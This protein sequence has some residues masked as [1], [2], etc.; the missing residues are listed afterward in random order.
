MGAG[1][2]YITLFPTW[3]NEQKESPLGPDES[4]R[5]GYFR[6]WPPPLR[7]LAW[8]IEIIWDVKPR[9]FV[10]VDEDKDAGDY[11]VYFGRIEALG[12]DG[13]GPEMTEQSGEITVSIVLHIQCGRAAYQPLRCCSLDSPAPACFCQF[14][15]SSYLYRCLSTV[16]R[17]PRKKKSLCTRV[18]LQGTL[19]TEIIKRTERSSPSPENHCRSWKAVSHYFR[20]LPPYRRVPMPNCCSIFLRS[21]IL[22]DKYCKGLSR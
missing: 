11:G 22:L 17:H 9:D 6:K 20:F 8:M 1:E 15:S 3:W 18:S 7:W 19:N 13:R 14:F 12:K 21:G 16:V 4:Q 2:D 10:Q 5:I